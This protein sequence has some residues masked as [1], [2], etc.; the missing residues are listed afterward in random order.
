MIRPLR[1]VAIAVLVLFGLL[2][3]NAT[4][5]QVVEAR[6]LRT[7]PHNGRQ[8]VDRYR[9]DRGDI[10]AGDLVIAQSK[11]T[12]DNLRFLRSYP[13]G[14]EYA[15]LTGYYSLFGSTGIERAEDDVLSGD[16]PRLVVDRLTRLLTG[17]GSQGGSV[18]L[19][20][21]PSVQDAAYRALGSLHGAVVAIEPS[22]GRILA[23]VSSPSYD[24]SPLASHDGSVIVSTDDKLAA[25]PTRP[26]LDRATEQRYPPGSLFK[27]VTAAAALSSGRYAPDSLL[28]SPTKLR[29]PLTRIDLQNFGGEVCGDGVHISLADALRIS[30][31]TAFAGLGLALGGDAIRRQA[32]AF[33][34]GSSISGW[35][36]GFA[37]S[38]FP[39]QLDAP[40]T[41]LSAIGQYEVAL[42]PLQAAMIAAGVANN[43]I[44]MRPRLVD[45]VRGADLSVLDRPSNSIMSTAIS[46]AVA[47]LLAQMMEGVV[48]SGTGTAAAIPG[49]RVA[50]KTGTAQHQVG[51]PPH[52]WFIGFAPIGAA[53]VAVAV[54]V[55]DGG[56]LGSEATGGALAAPIAKAVMEAALALPPAAG[57]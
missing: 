7:D 25:D 12:G 5:V 57:R 54:L 13:F 4:Y 53:R 26:L 44:V 38:V 17:R 51:K 3:G 48:N 16:D 11:A 21:A 18:T 23:L 19:S 31:N 29:L 45:L 39:A 56:N 55:E 8:L 34:V 24:P 15:Q 22:T 35:P 40:Q 9:R 49:V 32:D 47:G 14:A 28:A 30:C 1:R 36:L 20:I 46:P 43:G 6:K 52:A 50:G 10:L 27:V 33:G 41:A 2:L 42:T 37:K